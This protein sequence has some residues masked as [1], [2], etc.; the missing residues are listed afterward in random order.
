MGGAL[1]SGENRPAMGRHRADELIDGDQPG[2][3]HFVFFLV[4]QRT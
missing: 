2:F 3:D 4:V 1:K